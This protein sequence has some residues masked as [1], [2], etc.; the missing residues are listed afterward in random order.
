MIEEN[1]QM[2]N[3]NNHNIE[4]DNIKSYIEFNKEEEKKKKLLI[5]EKQPNEQLPIGEGH[6]TEV[7]EENKD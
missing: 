7:I 6:E 2:S 1:H 3:N 4:Q 5:E